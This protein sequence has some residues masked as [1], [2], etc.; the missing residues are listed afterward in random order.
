MGETVGITPHLWFDREAREAA[1]RYCSVFPDSRIH[2]TVVLHDTPSGDA[3]VVSFSLAGQPFQAISAGPL[4]RF[5]PAISFIVN[6]DPSRDAEA[7]AHLDALWEAL[8]DGGVVRMRLDA[9]PFSPRYGWVE[10]RYGVNWELILSNP[11]GEPRPSIVPALRFGGDV[12]GKAEEAG[13]FYRSVFPGSRAGRLVR[14]PAGM[15]PELEGTVMF[16]DFRLG[17]SWFAAM[18]AAADHW[19]GFTGA[20]SFVIPCDT[21]D[22]IDR[23]WAALSA[24]PEA[25]ACG[26]CQDRYGV[27][28]QVVPRLLDT[29]MES[30]D[31][32]A[33]E[34]VTRAFLPMKKLDLAVLEAAAEGRDG[35]SG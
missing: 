19:S 20:I 28:W 6:L 1:E 25:E 23:Y 3:E 2:S 22:E 18:D 31:R 21:Q 32:A 12:Y 15:E 29:V 13:D 27:S 7:G 24:V 14:H 26:W 30:G 4:F 11:E 35:N 16:S 9:Y 8:A 10:D 5:T 17:G 34:R 33:I